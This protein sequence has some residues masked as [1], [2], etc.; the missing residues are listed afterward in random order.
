[1]PHPPLASDRRTF[2]KASAAAATL[3]AARGFAEVRGSDTLRVG[4][5]GCGGRGTGAAFNIAQAND[6][7]VIAALGDVFRDRLDGARGHLAELGEKC[8]VPDARCFVGFDAYRGVLASGIDLVVCA[9]PPHFRPAHLAAAIEAGVHAFIEKPVAVDP[10]GVRRVLAAAEVAA[11]KQLGIVAGT[12]RRHQAGYVETLKRVHAGAIGELRYARCSWNQGGLWHTDRKSEWSD[13]EWQLRNWLYFTWASGDHIVEQHVHNLDVLNWAFGAHPVRAIG[14]G[15]RQVR[16]EAVHGHVFDHFAI[17][18][19]YPGGA[20]ATS[21]CRQIDNCHNDVSE[22]LVGTKGTCNPAGRIDGEQPW[23]FDGEERNPYEQEQID[24]VASIRAG[25]PLNEGRRI[26]ESTLTAIM[27]RMSA[28]TGK[29]VTWEQALASKLDLAPPR[30]EF[31]PL[32][33]AEVAM[34]GRT[35][36]V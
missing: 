35:P 30:Y 24:L 19:E 10:T 16:T 3:A 34:P 28:Y 7:V 33:V 5:I 17:E 15:G 26:A 12:Q 6:G 11:A 1:M 2:L 31:G 13:M 21:W 4:A 22:L 8:D 14:M 36:L 32:P 27:S 29:E 20:R 9:T 18:L 25:A 23:A